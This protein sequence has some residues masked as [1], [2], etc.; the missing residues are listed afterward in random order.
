MTHG[1]APSQIVRDIMT[2]H[3]QTVMPE[4]RITDA[5][6]RFATEGLH[7]LPVVGADRRLV[8]IISQSDVLVAMLAE[9]TMV[10]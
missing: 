9:R 5:I 1:K 4:T 3:V 8:G 6:V 2:E 7:Y 10:P